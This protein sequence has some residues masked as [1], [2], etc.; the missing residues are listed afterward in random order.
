MRVNG[1]VLLLGLLWLTGC[2]STATMPGDID[3]AAWFQALN[4]GDAAYL[5][6]QLQRG[7]PA[8]LRRQDGWSSLEL[9]ITQNNR[10]LAKLLLEHGADPHGTTHNGDSILFSAVYAGDPELVRQLLKKGAS[11][12]QRNRHGF[13]PAELARARGDAEVFATLLLERPQRRSTYAPTLGAL[14]DPRQLDSYVDDP[15]A[16]YLLGRIEE[17]KRWRVDY[18]LVEAAYLAASEHPAAAFRLLERYADPAS[19]LYDMGK[20]LAWHSQRWSV[21]E[22]NEH[23]LAY[24]RQRAFHRPDPLTQ[25]LY[26]TTALLRQGSNDYPQ[27]ELARTLI[28]DAAENGLAMAQHEVGDRYWFYFPEEPDDRVQAAAWLYRAAENGHPKAAEALADRYRHDGDL[29]TALVWYRRAGELG[30]PYQFYWAATGLEQGRYGFPKDPEAAVQWYIWAAEYGDHNGIAWLARAHTTGEHGIKRDPMKAVELL[31]RIDRNREADELINEAL[32]LALDTG[33][34]ALLRRALKQADPASEGFRQTWILAAAEHDRRTARRFVNAGVDVDTVVGDTTALLAAIRGDNVGM[35]TWLIQQGASL[36]L[37]PSRHSP[38]TAAVDAGAIDSLRVLV[39]AG[40]PV[41]E[42]DAAGDTALIRAVRNGHT[43]TARL[44]LAAGADLNQADARGHTPLDWAQQ[45]TSREGLERL[46][47]AQDSL[48]LS[49]DERAAR[50]ASLD[51]AQAARER[52][53]RWLA[54]ELFDRLDSSG[55]IVANNDYQTTPWACVRDQMSGLTWVVPTEAGRYS[56]EHR[57]RHP[58]YGNDNCEREA[59][60]LATH[61]QLVRSEAL[62]GI[63]DWR[64]PAQAELKTLAFDHASPAFPNWPGFA[65][66]SWHDDAPAI[67]WASG[68]FGQGSAAISVV[69]HAQVLLV[70]GEAQPL[71]QRPSA[72]FHTT[73]FRYS[74]AG[75]DER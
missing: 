22:A 20:A 47:L 26:A 45:Q 16:Y 70:S 5:E 46:L 14:A 68:L 50:L 51:A 38:L 39:N 10:S 4:E 44:L 57:Y 30:D 11:V 74:D 60:D 71:P 55:Q 40:A 62:C 43:E 34:R 24:L 42:P 66:W 3:T 52:A 17:S 6:R 21:R 67:T 48:A 69:S 73:V 58:T 64:V 23:D 9:A 1:F 12:E 19:P 54:G 35:V 32:T 31:R 13:T 27:E 28:L 2:A 29:D 59:C 61:V 33:D 63:D 49:A 36:T 65:L 8:D 18:S 41:S 53:E 15:M 56:A 25:Y 72:W 75:A 7:V 37:A